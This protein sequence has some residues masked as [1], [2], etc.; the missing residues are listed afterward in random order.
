MGAWPAPAVSLLGEGAQG[1]SRGAG[2]PRSM[3]K[4]YARAAWGKTQSDR[5]L[6]IPDNFSS[7]YIFFHNIIAALIH[8]PPA[9]PEAHLLRHSVSAPTSTRRANSGA[10]AAFLASYWNP[11]EGLLSC[12]SPK[13]VSDE[14][15]IHSA[16]APPS[17]GVA[18]TT[19]QHTTSLVCQLL[20]KTGL[21]SSG[22][23]SYGESLTGSTPASA[24]RLLPGQECGTK[25]SL[26]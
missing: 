24:V 19:P 25:P 3:R 18:W 23:G 22:G 8:H 9:L 10:T 11:P 17:P 20:K 16:L 26:Y 15:V 5:R 12:S 7:A 4:D 14:S 1:R 13:P 21:S 6:S 2:T